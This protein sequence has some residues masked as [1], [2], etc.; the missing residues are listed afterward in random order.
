MDHIRTSTGS[1]VR[2]LG[3]NVIVPGSL[4]A[5]SLTVTDMAGNLIPNGAFRFG[6]LRG[7]S[8]VHSSFMVVAR[9]DASVYHAIRTAPTPHVVQNVTDG[10][11]R[12]ATLEDNLIVKPGDRYVPALALA[13]GGSS[14]N[15]RWQLLFVFGSATGATLSTVTR[16]F[17]STSTSWANSTGAA[18]EAPADAATLTI[19]LRRS[20]GGSFT[21]TAF[22]AN[23]EVLRQRDGATLI[24]PNSIT[25]D[26]IF[27]QNL[28]SLS[29][30][31]GEVTAGRIRSADSKFV[32]DLNAKTITITV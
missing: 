21:G 16:S 26:Q 7:W 18:V 25:T 15:I 22:A 17:T 2:L 27:A 31:M 20:G 14:P 4:S 1:A 11:S 12:T 5:S 28:S 13:A 6:D 24:T 32:I 9:N 23:I 3:D 29:A 8:G 10:S 19:Q 30:D